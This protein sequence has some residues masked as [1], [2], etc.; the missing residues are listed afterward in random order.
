MDRE[1]LKRWTTVGRA[2][3]SVPK[4]PVFPNYWTQNRW[5]KAIT[6]TPF[7][8]V[9]R[10]PLLDGSE[11]GDGLLET[12]V[13]SSKVTRSRCPVET[14]DRGEKGLGSS[15]RTSGSGR[16]CQGSWVQESLSRQ[17]QPGSEKRVLTSWDSEPLTP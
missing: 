12:G 3:T 4:D 10:L 6:G 13:L 16:L 7:D 14:R 1:V 8:S 2:R 11:T 9:L 15:N 17:P 5:V